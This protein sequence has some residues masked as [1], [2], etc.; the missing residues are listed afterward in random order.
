MAGQ[1]RPDRAT[2]LQQ[3]ARLVSAGQLSA[4]QDLFEKALQDSP[5]DPDLRFEL[6]MVF[7]R[8]RNWSKAA[9]NY[10]S[11]LSRKPASVKPLFYLAQ[12]YFMESDLESA[13]ETIAQAASIAPNDGQVCQKY[14]EY[15][16]ATIETRKQG[17][18]WLEKARHLNPDLARIDF[19]IGKTQFDLTDFR[20]AASNFDIALKKNSNDGEAAFF[21]GE[22]WASL[23]EWERA[24]NSY[25]DALAH[26][27]V[28]GPAYYGMGRA[29][30]EASVF[31]AAVEPLRRALVLQPSLIQAHFQLAK[32]YRQLGRTKEAQEQTKLFAAMT[33]RI[34]TSHEL[35]NPE[36]EAA[37]KQ[38]K[39]LLE[40]DKE[41]EALSVLAKLPDSQGPENSEP[42]YLLGTMYYSMGRKDDAKRVLAI[43]RAKAPKSPR[44]AAYLGM[45]QLSAGEAV[46]AEDSFRSA[47]A[48]DS[49]E[50][51]A[52]IGMG[53]IRYQQQRW[54]E[55][56]EDL[57]KS[58]TADPDALFLLCDAYYRIGKPEQAALTAE[59]IRALGADRKPL[60]DDLD[61]LMAQHRSNR[62]AE[63]P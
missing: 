25:S 37:W 2:T 60:L 29:L 35:T 40:K 47:L 21:L 41:Q 8:Q 56:I 33:D 26:D 10:R 61:R 3:G 59:V 44:I 38:V 5:D 30:V 17:L 57:E 22:S 50:T 34:D 46:A 12:T 52:L 43:A 58:R 13:R 51:L 62:A 23:G 55:A 1:T 53:G 16:S 31:D 45:V 36:E 39:P 9:E 54:P 19:Q 18:T 11:S 24:R 49:T 42:Y 27:Y 14:G 4:A 63:G 6:G 28:T 15:L 48:L 32:A 20:S 7:F